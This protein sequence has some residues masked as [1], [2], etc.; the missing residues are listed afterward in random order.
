[1]QN[2][3]SLPNT[4]RGAK[5]QQT[6]IWKLRVSRVGEM[7]QT[8]GS[9]ALNQGLFSKLVGEHL[10]CSPCGGVGLPV[11]GEQGPFAQKGAG[12]GGAAVAFADEK[13]DYT[14]FQWFLFE[15]FVFLM[16]APRTRRWFF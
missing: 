10:E 9:E 1:M 5:N 2:T 6:K 16:A 14:V 7:D 13:L 3:C 11:R 4:H 12:A 15:E 8:L